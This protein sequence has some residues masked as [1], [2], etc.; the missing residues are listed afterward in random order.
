[1][2]KFRVKNKKTTAIAFK[3]VILKKHFYGG[4]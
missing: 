3:T 2:G 1:V 4:K